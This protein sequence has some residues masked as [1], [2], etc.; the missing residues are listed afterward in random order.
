MQYSNERKEA[1]L[2]KMVPPHFSD[3]FNLTL[4][5]AQHVFIDPDIPGRLANLIPLFSN[6]RNRFFLEFLCVFASLL[7]H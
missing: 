3:S 5:S 1:V 6:Q 4:P 7:F 2:R